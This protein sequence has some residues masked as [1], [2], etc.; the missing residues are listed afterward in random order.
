MKKLM[1]SLVL[2]AAAVG[3]FGASNVVK[4]DDAPAT[5]ATT[6]TTGATVT[7]EGGDLS[8]TKVAKDVTFK[9]AKTGDVYTNG[10]SDAQPVT[11]TV[12][13][14]LSGS[15]GWTITAKQDGW[16]SQDASATGDTLS[17]AKLSLGAKAITTDAETSVAN[18]DYGHTDAAFGENTLNLAMDKGTTVK[19]GTYSNTITWTLSDSV[20]DTPK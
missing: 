16:K 7:F 12:D 2:A 18:G 14:F 10:Y 20:S 5:P 13:D 8:L 17:T 6:G 3:L 4:A 15:K 1:T 9:T 19:A 11:A